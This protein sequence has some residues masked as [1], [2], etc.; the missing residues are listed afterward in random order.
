MSVMI[1]G[2]GDQ[3]LVFAPGQMGLF[4][5]VNGWMICPMATASIHV[6]N[7]SMSVNGKAV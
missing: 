4:M 5:R 1:L 2:D 6:K 3:A 7:A